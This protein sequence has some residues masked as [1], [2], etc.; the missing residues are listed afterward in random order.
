[1][2]NELARICRFGPV[3][4]FDTK[5][6]H[7]ARTFAIGMRMGRSQRAPSTVSPHEL[8]AGRPRSQRRERI[9]CF[10]QGI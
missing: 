10:D 1:M 6:F 4:L 9:E 7:R 8:E 2:E 3:E 5:N